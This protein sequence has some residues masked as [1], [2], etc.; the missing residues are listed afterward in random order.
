MEGLRSL[1]FTFFI[2]LSSTDKSILQFVL[3]LT[4]FSTDLPKYPFAKM[5]LQARLEI[6]SVHKNH[7]C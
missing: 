6:L 3:R 7:L 4:K 5:C 1:I 2:G